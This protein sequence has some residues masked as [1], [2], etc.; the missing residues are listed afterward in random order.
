MTDA[1]DETQTDDTRQS[2]P[3]SQYVG[4]KEMLSRKEADLAAI[5][6]KVA[7]TEGKLTEHTTKVQEL[8]AEVKTRTDEITKLKESAVN[9]D[10]YKAAVNELTTLKTGL[11]D[12]QKQTIIDGSGGK[13]TLEDIKDFTQDQITLFEKGLKVGEVLKTPKPDL[14]GGGGGDGAHTTGAQKMRAG[15]DQ[16]HPEGK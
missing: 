10:E 12:L 6:A 2:V 15:W 9:P 14:K 3:M 4:V 16:L 11:L 13:V 8:T 7:L 1:T 5:E